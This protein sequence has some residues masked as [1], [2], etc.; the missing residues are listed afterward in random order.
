MKRQ[1]RLTS[2]THTEEQQLNAQQTRQEGSQEFASVDDML[3]HDALH[4]PVPPAIAHRLEK[5]ISEAPRSNG[6][7]W[8]RLFGGQER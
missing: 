8:R 2:K 1:N 6:S 3:R 7:W 4:T 5:S